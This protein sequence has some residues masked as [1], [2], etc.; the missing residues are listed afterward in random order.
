M[1]QVKIIVAP[2]FKFRVDVLAK[3]QAKVPRGGVP[4]HGILFEAVVGR[5]VE[6][7]AKPPDRIG[8]WLLRDEKA[9]VG[10]AGRNK[11]VMRVDHQRDAHRFE[12]AAR[13]LRAVRGS[14]RGHG[15]AVNV[16]KIH[17]RLFED[18]AVTQHAAAPAAARFA[19]PA[20]FLEFTAVCGGQ[21]LA[22]LILQLQ[23]ERFDQ[24]CIRFHQRFLECAFW[25]SNQLK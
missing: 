17:A 22:N 25:L 2:L 21:F 11:R 14:G 20:I 23:Q 9:D 16:G 15:V 6:T 18:A 12:A 8:S 5:H 4:V 24:L 19:L 7:A 3:R 13:Q 1:L 10:V